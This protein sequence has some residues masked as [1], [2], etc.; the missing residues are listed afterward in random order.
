MTEYHVRLINGYKDKL[1]PE[2]M[3]EFLHYFSKEEIVEMKELN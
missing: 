1:T 2:E 3:A